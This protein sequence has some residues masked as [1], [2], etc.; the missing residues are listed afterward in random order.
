MS[1]RNTGRVLEKHEREVIADARGSS[2]KSH[3]RALASFFL[4]V[5]AVIVRAFW[6]WA[7]RLK[8]ASS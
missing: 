8:T 6:R 7:S 3:V 5:A 2:L 4:V 1:N